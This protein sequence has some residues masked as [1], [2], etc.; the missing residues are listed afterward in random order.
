MTDNKIEFPAMSRIE[1]RVKNVFDETKCKRP[2]LMINRSTV[3]M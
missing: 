2:C 1:V 3:V